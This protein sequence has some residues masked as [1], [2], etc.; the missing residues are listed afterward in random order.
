[1]TAAAPA[2]PMSLLGRAKALLFDRFF[3]TKFG[4]SVFL[5]F[6]GLILYTGTN[7]LVYRRSLVT[8]IHA[9][10]YRWERYLPFVPLMVVPYWSIDPLY[11]FGP[12]FCTSRREL[13]TFV[14]RMTAGII[15]A[16]ACFMLW[17]LREG[18][19]RPEVTGISGWLFRRLMQVDRPFNMAPS[20]HIVEAA[21]LWVI[22]ARHTRGG[23]RLFVHIWFVLIYLSTVLTFQHHVFD[24]ITGQILAIVLFYIFPDVPE[25]YEMVQAPSAPMNPRIG[26]RYA[27]GALILALLTFRWGW[28]MIWPAVA[29]AIM[30][31]AYVAL[32]HRVLRKCGP[33]LPASTRSILFPYLLGDWLMYLFYRRSG[34]AYTQVA[35]G[36]WI[37][38]RLWPREASAL[39]DAGV[40]SVLDL[41]AEC[42]ESPLLAKLDYRALP[43]LDLTVPRPRVMR[44]AVEFIRSRAPF[45]GV[46]VHC[47][48]GL[49]R[50][51]CV[52]AAYLLSERIA[53]TPEDAIAKVQ[54]ARPHVRIPTNALR[55]LSEFEQAARGHGE[56]E[57][58]GLPQKPDASLRSA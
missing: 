47:T 25:G 1:M 43:V 32:D 46:Y 57:F 28:P 24:I 48:M 52:A 27:A 9:Y 8:P 36:L 30:A 14:K 49:S 6:L 53:Q 39:V 31:G 19:A 21:L 2:E 44:E 16:C 55:T 50:C 56:S 34:E 41:S 10:Y 4:W 3:L 22:Y 54:E 12:L 5:C 13:Y 42:S 51:A 38:R 58:S 40:T 37:G 33:K 7:Y 45:G 35:P 20:L 15:I 26:L 17:P 23:L 29:L 18:F 11:F